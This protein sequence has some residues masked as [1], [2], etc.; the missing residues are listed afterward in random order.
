M[1]PSKQHG[2]LHFLTRN[3]FSFQK[4]ITLKVDMKQV[5]I[6]KFTS[7]RKKSMCRYVDSTRMN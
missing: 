1:Q 6:F 5:P 4:R 7:I 3:N 2:I